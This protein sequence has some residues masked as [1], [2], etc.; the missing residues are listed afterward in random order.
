MTSAQA[1]ALASK[2]I[3]ND[4]EIAAPLLV[5]ADAFLSAHGDAMG[6]K[7]ATDVKRF[8]YSKTEDSDRNMA[9]FISEAG[10]DLSH[11]AA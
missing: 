2:I 5:L 9:R 6:E 8:L 3:Q 1:L 11:L 10:S 4:P 7:M